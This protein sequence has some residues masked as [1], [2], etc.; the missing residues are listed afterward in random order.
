MDTVALLPQEDLATTIA[1]QTVDVVFP[2]SGDALP[3]QQGYVLYAALSKMIPASHDAGNHF[4]MGTIPC[5]KIES[6]GTSR[7]RIVKDASLR[8]R[9][10]VTF[11]PHLLMLAGASLDIHGHEIRLGNP[12][13]FRL[14]AHPELYA[15]I[16]I[17]KGFEDAESF[18]DAVQR[19][20]AHIGVEASIMIPSDPKTGL[21]QRK[22]LKIKK[23]TIVGFPVVLS[24]LT[25]EASLLVQANG[26]GGK[27]KMGAGMFQAVRPLTRQDGSWD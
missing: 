23:Q 7:Y 25:P 6:V 8:F 26:V 3:A 18:Q 4:F 5:E 1:L 17:I 22:I 10:R 13:P 9:C 12:T 21:P 27:S 2:V 15:R 19:Q 16:V 14:Q 24:G 20:L 11:L